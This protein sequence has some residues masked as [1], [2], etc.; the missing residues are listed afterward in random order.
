MHVIA[1]KA[2]ALKEALDPAFRVY[3]QQVLDNARAMAGVFL[4]RGYNVVSGGTDD[5]LFLVDLADKG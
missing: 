1:A 3:Q 2:V 4:A 5:H